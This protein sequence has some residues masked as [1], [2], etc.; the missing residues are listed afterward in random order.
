MGRKFIG[1]EL[2][3]SYFNQAVKNLRAAGENTLQLSAIDFDVPD[4]DGFECEVA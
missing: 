2:K 4:D 1:F 3:Q